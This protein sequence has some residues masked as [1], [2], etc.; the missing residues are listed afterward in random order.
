MTIEIKFGKDT[1]KPVINPKDF[2]DGHAYMY[3]SAELKSAVFIPNQSECGRYRAFSVCG[4]YLILEN[5][6]SDFE[7]VDLKIEVTRR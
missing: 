4:R 6:D 1:V 5:D 7:E 2:Q 3:H